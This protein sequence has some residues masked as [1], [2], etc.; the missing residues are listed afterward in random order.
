MMEIA[1]SPKTRLAMTVP[2]AFVDRH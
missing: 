2:D 1:S